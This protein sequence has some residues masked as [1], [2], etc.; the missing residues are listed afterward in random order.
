MAWRD[1]ALLPCAKGM[2]S[3]HDLQQ[4]IL[5]DMRVDLRGGD[6]GMA[7][8]GLHAAQVRSASTR[9]VAKHGAGHAA[10]ACRGRGS[11]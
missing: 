11:P 10:K 2:G 1:R 3:L 8:H 9:C 6:V 4:S 7:E 5:R